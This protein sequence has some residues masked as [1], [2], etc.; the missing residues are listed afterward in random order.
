MRGVAM[1][2]LAEDMVRLRGEIRVLRREREAFVRDLRTAVPGI[3]AGYRKAHAQTAQQAAAE[4][5][6]FVSRM[7]AGYRKAHA[8]MAQQTAAERRAFVSGM[9]KGVAGVLKGIAADLAGFRQ[10]WY[11]S[12]PAEGRPGGRVEEALSVAAER[13]RGGRKRREQAE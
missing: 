11:G 5:R 6:A 7:L 1:G 9:R 12:G 13:P 10:A 2:T 3:L 4:R 8:Q